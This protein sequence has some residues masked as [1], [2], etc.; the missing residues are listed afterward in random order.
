MD[1][2][3]IM[4]MAP[5]VLSEFWFWGGHDFCRDLREWT[6]AILTSDAPPLVHSVSYGWQDDL[7]KIG[8]KQEDIDDVDVNFAKL[9]AMGIT[10]V[11]ASGYSGSGWD[12]G[13]YP[14]GGLNTTIE[15]M[16]VQGVMKKVIDLTSTTVEDCVKEC[17]EESFDTDDLTATHAWTY[18]LPN[19]SHP[20]GVCVSYSEVS[21]VVPTNDAISGGRSVPG[22]ERR[23]TLYPSW[24]ASSPWVTAV[25][26][27]RFVDQQLDNPEM[28]SDFFGSGGG[29]STM[30]GAFEDQQSA[31]QHYL[32]VAPQLAPADKAYF[33][34]GG[35]ATPDVS[36]LGEGYL[37][38]V[39][40]KLSK[41]VGTSASAPAFAGMVSL[42]N[43]ARLAAGA[44]PMGYL[45]PFLYQHPE[46][47]TDILLGHDFIGIMPIFGIRFEYEY[48]FNC[49]EG[50]DP[51]T[52]L[53]TPKFDQLLASAIAA[54]PIRDTIV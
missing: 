25:G 8:C 14:C 44:P 30:F 35:R 19:A 20:N 4:G 34:R 33:P 28:A 24:P 9:A 18:T 13:L 10:I 45:N 16:A 2:E 17:C 11:V 53:G 41:V 50:W 26:A 23:S 6:A 48:G 42:L 38:I 29:F 32:E 22:T 39:N 7:G 31:V 5:G 36:L 1:I 46:A 51:I 43:E 27:T 15:G 12:L 54:T 3:Y 21:G 37:I 47:F 49:T 40:G 52:G